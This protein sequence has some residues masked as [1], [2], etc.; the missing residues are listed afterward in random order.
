MTCCDDVDGDDD[1]DYKKKNRN[2]V[3]FSGNQCVDAGKWS[4]ERS[5]VRGQ[6]LQE[7][8]AASCTLAPVLLSFY[9]FYTFR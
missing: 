5:D 4:V 9:C 2:H 7:V 1:D 8:T 3:V 6:P